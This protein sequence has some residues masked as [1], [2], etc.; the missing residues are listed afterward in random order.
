MN[1][2]CKDC[3]AWEDDGKKYGKC[4]LYPPLYV[5]RMDNQYHYEK[6]ACNRTA[7]EDWCMEFT[8]KGN[9]KRQRIEELRKMGLLSGLL[10]CPT[11]GELFRAS[12]REEAEEHMQFHKAIEGKG[13]ISQQELDEILHDKSII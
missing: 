6:T 10:E 7:P 9:D 4:H 1:R 2:A 13:I 3:E 11:C 8:P 12:T 5:L